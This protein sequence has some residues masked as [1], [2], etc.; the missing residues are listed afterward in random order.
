[1]YVTGCCL[2]QRMKSILFFLF[3][4]FVQAS[5]DVVVPSR[6]LHGYRSAFVKRCHEHCLQ[7]NVHMY[8][9]FARVSNPTLYLLSMD[10]S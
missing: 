1:M 2:Q 8:I 6:N 7:R 3:R 4:L 10:L 5:I 9:R